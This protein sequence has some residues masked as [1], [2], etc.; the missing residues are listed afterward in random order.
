[1]EEFD[2]QT[3]MLLKKYEEWLS[4]S[5]N[6]VSDESKRPKKASWWGLWSSTKN[7][8]NVEVNEK[9]ILKNLQID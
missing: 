9:T 1:M 7:T 8:N 6:L 4:E 3:K 5:S 2:E